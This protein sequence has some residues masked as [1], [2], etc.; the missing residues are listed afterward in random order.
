M[1]HD[2]DSRG[3]KSEAGGEPDDAEL[4]RAYVKGRSQEAFAELVRRHLTLVY[5]AALRLVAGDVHLA[6]DVT[7]MVFADLARKAA[8][9]SD[10]PV[11][12]GWLH[13]STRYAAAKAVR[14]ERRRQAREDKAH[15]M[16]EILHDPDAQIDWERVQPVLDEALGELGEVDREAVLLRFFEGQ[17]LAMVGARLALTEAA[18]R[19][20]VDR[21][22]DKLRGLLERRGVTST[23]AALAVALAS[24]ASVAAPAGLAASVAGAAAAGV[25][26]TGGAAGVL[27]F[28][29]TTNTVAGIAGVVVLLAL[30]SAVF[31]FNAVRVS[32]AA[33]TAVSDE[34]AELRARLAAME[35]RAVQADEG[36]AALQAEIE[37]L[38]AGA[39]KATASVGP[40]RP[41]ARPPVSPA[42]YVLDHPEARPAYLQRA[43]LTAKTRFN[44]F[45][46]S[47]EL[48]TEQQE[49]FLKTTMGEAD[50]WLE[51][52]AV[53][54]AAGGLEP[55]GPPMDPVAMEQIG[56]IAK[57][58][59]MENESALRELLGDQFKPLMQ[60]M[61]T[62]GERN[63]VDQLASQLYYTDSP[64]T[65]QQADQ[66]TRILAENAFR[67]QLTPA[68]TNTMG[69]QFIS[70]E[71]LNGAM[72]QGM[73]F[74]GPVA[75]GVN[76]DFP[77]MQHALVTDAAVARAGAALTPTQLAALRVLQA[78]QVARLQLAP[79]AEKPKDAKAGGKGTSEN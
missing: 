6:Q 56:A 21:A 15:T 42:E 17:P 71:A 41:A 72:A 1:R 45:F 61:A 5:S 22:L 9:L 76:Q 46:Q 57:R 70:R 2:P 60:Y 43:A 73:N 29:S 40:M 26:G 31:E 33:L 50:S 58:H 78:E 27:A 8:A 7:Q 62:L 30:G 77:W 44:R 18:A 4:L 49:R 3:R 74:N 19:S 52:L 25:A 20:R 28:M 36:R 12:A 55:G 66:L 65:P 63:A 24:Q 38:R 53:K 34:R 64:L 13:T 67:P 39:G 51:M 54:R 11:L 10:R 37:D 69:S 48:T 59:D 75:L 14:T 16:Q 23:S 47:A 79:P 68:P 35:K 32:D